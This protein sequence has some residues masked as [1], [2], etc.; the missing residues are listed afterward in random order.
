MLI[1]TMLIVC[2]RVYC[3]FFLPSALVHKIN[4]DVTDIDSETMLL[5][6]MSILEVK[7]LSFMLCVCVC[8][9]V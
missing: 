1:T 2:E 4:I 5:L 7:M 8:V 6:P 9:C 3:N